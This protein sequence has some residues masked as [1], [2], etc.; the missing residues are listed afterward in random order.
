[1]EI[2]MRFRIAWGIAAALFFSSPL[3]FAALPPAILGTMSAEVRGPDKRI[4]IPRTI[5][6]LTHMGVNT[7]YYLIWENPS[8]WNDLPAFCDAAARQNIQVWAY[9]VPWSETPPQSRWL[10]DRRF[11]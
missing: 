7:Y 2:L 6:A 1:M 8:D 4:D 11:L 3:T 5:E 10:R 9:V